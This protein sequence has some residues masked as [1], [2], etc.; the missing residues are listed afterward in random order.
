MAML[1][2]T[3][4]IRTSRT[5]QNAGLDINLDAALA[6]KPIELNQTKLARTAPEVNHHLSDPN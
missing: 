4:A 2:I 3:T 6:P 1:N 5:F